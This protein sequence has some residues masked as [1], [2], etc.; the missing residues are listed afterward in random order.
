MLPV[1]AHIPGQPATRAVSSSAARRP[2]TDGAV[3][4]V[5]E[6]AD[7]VAHVPFVTVA[8][9]DASGPLLLLTGAGAGAGADPVSGGGRTAARRGRG[10]TLAD[11]DIV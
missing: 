8:L 6:H 11:G 3:D 4:E 2:L 7:H 9:T 1:Y 10:S 5:E